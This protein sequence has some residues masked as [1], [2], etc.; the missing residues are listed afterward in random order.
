MQ[1]LSRDV[2]LRGLSF[3]VFDPWISIVILMCF[4]TAIWNTSIWNT[5]LLFVSLFFL[6]KFIFAIFLGLV[7]GV[8]AGRTIVI[9]AAPLFFWGSTGWIQDR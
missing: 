5:F 4:D 7:A 3:R 8:V 1:K 9:V 6:V 2:S